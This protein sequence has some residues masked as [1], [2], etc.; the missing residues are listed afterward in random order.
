MDRAVEM[1]RGALAVGAFRGS[2]LLRLGE[3]FAGMGEEAGTKKEEEKAKPKPKPKPPVT[4][5]LTAEIKGESGFEKAELQLMVAKDY[6][7]SG[8]FSGRR[9]GKGFSLSLSGDLTKDNQISLSGESGK[10]KAEV[11]G[12]LSKSG[13]STKVTGKIWQQAFST[14]M[15]AQK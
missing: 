9:E 8:K 3:A 10:N 7:I 11:K 2:R 13:A 4:G 5:R 15:N 12:T 1:V 6:T 14:S